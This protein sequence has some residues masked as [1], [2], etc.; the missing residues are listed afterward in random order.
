MSGH[1]E[2]SKVLNIKA[3]IGNF[4]FKIQ[5]Y[6]S[7]SEQYSQ[8][9]EEVSIIET[10]VLAHMTYNCAMMNIQEENMMKLNHY[11]KKFTLWKKLM[12]IL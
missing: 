2:N 8:S 9:L 10:D 5:D 12:M 4:Y 3:N 7:A 1:A 6:E 11:S